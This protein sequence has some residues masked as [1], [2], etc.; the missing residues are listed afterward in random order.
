MPE[1]RSVVGS[2]LWVFH[3]RITPCRLR[4]RFLN[5]ILWKE[6]I[7]LWFEWSMLPTSAVVSTSWETNLVSIAPSSTL[8]LPCVTSILCVSKVSSVCS[9]VDD[10]LQKSRKFSV[11]EMIQT[12]PA[13]DLQKPLKSKKRI[14]KIFKN[15]DQGVIWKWGQSW[16]RQ[17]RGEERAVLEEH[18]PHWFACVSFPSSSARNNLALGRCALW[19]SVTRQKIHVTLD[20]PHTLIVTCIA[21]D[22]SSILMALWMTRNVPFS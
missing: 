10:L 21:L 15:Q 4:K 9:G 22:S 3:R 6:G 2:R 8:S 13:L 19:T 18:R 11:W 5:R 16:K 7:C 20:R 12:L 1:E 17:T 14:E